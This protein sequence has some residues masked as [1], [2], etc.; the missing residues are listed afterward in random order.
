MN[1]ILSSM[2][3]LFPVFFK[4]RS[5]LVPT[6]RGWFLVGLILIMLIGLLMRNIPLFLAVTD[7]IK[8]DVLVIEGWAPDYAFEAAI[9]EFRRH[10]YD[11]LYVTGG[12]MERGAFL[13]EYRTYAG[14]G[15]A[16]LRRMGESSVEAVPSLKTRKD[17]TY[18]S[19][20]ALRDRFQS[21][22]KPVKS[23][24]LLS[25]GAHA[26]RSKLLFEKALGPEIKVGVIAVN[27]QDYDSAR[28]WK[29]SQGFRVVVDE[30]IAYVY[31]RFFFS[32]IQG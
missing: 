17:R 3:S 29:S 9:T 7:P 30:W 1:G 11:K 12:P 27:D 28:W 14:L 23:I 16:I 8:A 5:C 22:S 2:S 6:W 32:P 25:L 24:N 21:E 15:E 13:S 19:A 31:A 10:P 18:S 26:R 4:R 20:M